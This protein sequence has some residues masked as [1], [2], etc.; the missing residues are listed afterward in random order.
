MGSL[1]TYLR[2]RK[3][4]AP[5]GFPEVS[6]P[7]GWNANTMDLSDPEPN[8]PI[9]SL[10]DLPFPF[11]P[12]SIIPPAA[13]FPSPFSFLFLSPSFSLRRKPDNARRSPPQLWVW[14]GRWPQKWKVLV[15]HLSGKSSLPRPRLSSQLGTAVSGVLP[16]QTSSQGWGEDGRSRPMK[17]V[18]IWK[19][20]KRRL[21]KGRGGEKGWPGDMYTKALRKNNLWRNVPAAAWR[22]WDFS[23][24][25]R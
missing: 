10:S 16:F 18:N 3:W 24:C 7:R 6:I 5:L 12:F 20:G 19:L 14:G 17:W 2:A 22:C 15:A 21:E 9:T 23:N 4:D 13:L 1:Y 11:P 8:Q 25:I